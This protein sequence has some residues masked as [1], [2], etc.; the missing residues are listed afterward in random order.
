MNQRD[1]KNFNEAIQS[2]RL[3]RRY[4]ILDR[5]SNDILNQIYVDPM[6]NDA[7]LNLCLKDNT[8]VLVGRKG[9]GKSTIFMRMQN[10]LRKSK[11]TMTCY[12]DVKTIFDN[13][14]RNYTTI[15]YLQLKN[16]KEIEVY[17]LQ[18][19]FILD[20]ISELID[21]IK[22]NYI[23]IIESIKDK[24]GI[25]SKLSNSIQRLEEIKSR[26]QNNCHLE[27]IEL[28]ALQNV[29]QSVKGEQ[30]SR[31]EM[32]DSTKILVAQTSVNLDLRLEENNSIKNSEGSEQKYN[33]IFARIFEITNLVEEIKEI[34]EGLSMKRLYL[35]LDDYSEI[36][37]K[38]LTM[39]ADLIVNTLNNTSDNYI[40]LKIAAYPGRVELGELD[41]QKIDVRYL[42]Y[43]QLYA[44]EKRDEMELAAIDYTRRIIETRLKIYTDH[45][46]EHYFD[47]D[48]ASI[49]EYLKLIFKMTLNVV[50]HI[51]LILDYA[52]D[53]SVTQGEKITI[54]DLNEAAKRFY[55]ERLSLFFEESKSAQMA[56][57]ERVE[58]FQLEELLK[59]IVKR[60]KE[61][62]TNI[63][64]NKYKAQIFESDR[65]NPYTSHFYILKNVEYMLASLEL[66]F[67]VSKYN[68]MIS[69]TGE[70]VSIYALNY[71]LCLNESIR[72]GKPEGNT[73]RT[74]FIE[75]PFNFNSLLTEFL[76]KTKEIKCTECGNTYEETYLTILKEYDM[77]C[78][79][80]G[81]K[82]SVVE[83]SK[84][85]E[86]YHS[87]I[88]EIEKKGNLLDKE[89]YKFMKLAIMKGGRVSTREMALELDTTS[90]K[91]GW[92]TK[93]LEEGYYYLTKFKENGKIM[94]Q[95]TELGKESVR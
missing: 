22:K 72:W 54:S 84:V 15:N 67:F 45:G 46:L 74:Y 91:I 82:G 90:Q 65:T 14:K 50:R 61:I 31:N 62:K 66:N 93:K 64:T 94:Y 42:D 18:R 40:K 53:Y 49:K 76:K 35:I 80:C 85:S 68:E 13:A 39:F 88:E 19:Q 52:Q 41:R 48:K 89:L 43:Y 21:E 16:S 29:E 24:L 33:R 77:N 86:L 60:E 57:E 7:I 70:K 59:S 38:S 95:I 69:K 81:S 2:L 17:S 58:I 47:T 44:N 6:K 30:V 79:K 1:I 23:S 37:Q 26:I 4:E 92:I 51:G 56:Y 28:Q 55:N 36:D 87:Q 11:E 9:T 5:K 75:S 32:I 71:G 73:Y 3:Y 27:N 20:F 25:S 63:R 34:L 12:I 8:T 78:L 10:E 83:T